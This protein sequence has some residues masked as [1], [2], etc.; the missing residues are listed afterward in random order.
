MIIVD[1]R[2]LAYAPSRQAFLFGC[3]KA[4]QNIPNEYA[5]QIEDKERRQGISNLMCARSIPFVGMTFKGSLEY[6]W[7]SLKG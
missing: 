5:S 3:C 2:S 7:P 4:V 6:M 1:K